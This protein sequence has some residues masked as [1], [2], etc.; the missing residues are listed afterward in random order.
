MDQINSKE[1][2]SGDK[3]CKKII[4]I[5]IPTL[6]TI[7]IFNELIKSSIPNVVIKDLSKESKKIELMSKDEWINEQHNIDLIT[8][9][10]ENFRQTITKQILEGINF[11]FT[12]FYI[13]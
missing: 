6:A 3:S 5:L 12:S 2:L 13:Y 4:A 10:P 1:I 7:A 11:I 8:I 9:T